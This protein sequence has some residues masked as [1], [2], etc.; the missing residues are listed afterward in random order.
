MTPLAFWRA[1]LCAALFLCPVVPATA[2]DFGGYPY[3]PGTSYSSDRRPFDGSYRDTYNATDWNGLYV[4][5]HFG[6]GAGSSDATGAFDRSADIS[7]QFGGV[8]A[9]Y[10][11]QSSSL[12]AGLEVDGDWSGIDGS[13]TLSGGDKTQ[14]AIDWMS[15]MRLR[16]GM[17]T[18]N[19]LLYGTGGFAFAG[20]DTSVT[21]PGADSLTSQTLSG[22]VLGAGAEYAFTRSVSA[23]V[24]ALHYGFGEERFQTSR[25][26]ID[27]DVDAT[28][29]RGGLSI[30]LN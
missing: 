25:G 20:L 7:G 10:N 3:T 1:P 11:F 28:T 12:V 8:H 16:L 13:A 22:Y 19:W 9:G 24:E 30:K 6:W 14:A 26:P 5:G 21:G 27:A 18:G 29:I 23:R 15:S 4:G 2:A 17:T